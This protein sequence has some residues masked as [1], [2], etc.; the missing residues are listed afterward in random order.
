MRGDSSISSRYNHKADQETSLSHGVKVEFSNFRRGLINLA[1][2]HGMLRVLIDQVVTP[3]ADED[4]SV[5]E[6]Q[7][8]G[9]TDENFRKLFLAWNILSLGIN[10]NIKTDS[11]ILSSV[12]SSYS[13]TT[14]GAQLRR[15]KSLTS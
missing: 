12:F 13:A 9:F 10:I 2:Q 7:V 1:K 6:I 15:M 11:G 5:E 14:R 4:K 8:M 3:V